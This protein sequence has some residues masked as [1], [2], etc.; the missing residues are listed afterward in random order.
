MG[1]LQKD[2]AAD[3]T[4]D[5]PFK[6]NDIKT[7]G[8]TPSTTWLGEA[9]QTRGKIHSM[10]EATDNPTNVHNAGI[11]QLGEVKPTRAM[12]K[13]PVVVCI[14]LKSHTMN[15]TVTIKYQ[16]ANAFNY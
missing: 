8:S 2:C 4:Q 15:D 3:E 5:H 9:Y 14:L 7:S 6:E 11:S 1:C 16:F 13:A 12:M 10:D